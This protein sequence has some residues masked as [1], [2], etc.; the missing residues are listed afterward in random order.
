[1]KGNGKEYWRKQERDKRQRN[2]RAGMRDFPNLGKRKA[3]RCNR[4][5]LEEREG[6][7]IRGRVGK[8][9]NVAKGKRKRSISAVL[10]ETGLQLKN[11]F[12]VIT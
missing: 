6:M 11:V 4:V 12:I 10:V 8:K 7:A 2:G 5:A 1:M 9:I 3:G